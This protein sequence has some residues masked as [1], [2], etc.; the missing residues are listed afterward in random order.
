MITG[1]FVEVTKVRVLCQPFK[2]LVDEGKREVIFPG[3]LV[4]HPV[5]DAHS[6]SG[7]CPLR[8]EL[9]PLITD[10]RHASR[11]RDYLDWANPLAILHGVYDARVQQLEDLFLD[12][13]PHHIVK[14]PLMF[15]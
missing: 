1:V 14:P 9:V 6:P 11:L 5:I 10:Y 15:S 2:H 12:Y 4:K 3:C 8:H 7:H 13:L